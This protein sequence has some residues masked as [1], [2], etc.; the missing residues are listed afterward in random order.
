VRVRV[1]GRRRITVAVAVARALLREREGRM[2]ERFGD[3][4]FRV[5][6]EKDALLTVD[7]GVAG[8][9]SAHPKKK[10]LV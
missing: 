7:N 2:N 5:V 4:P 9:S 8:R 10:P 6:I 3:A 1:S